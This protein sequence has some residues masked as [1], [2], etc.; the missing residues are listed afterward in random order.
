MLV[1]NNK[2]RKSVKKRPLFSF[3]IILSIIIAIIILIRSVTYRNAADESNKLAVLAK[4]NSTSQEDSLSKLTLPNVLTIDT[5]NMITMA[6]EHHAPIISDASVVNKE[7]K[8][9][10]INDYSKGNFRVHVAPSVENEP[11]QS[12]QSKNFKPPLKEED[13]FITSSVI[14][15]SKDRP[16]IS[17]VRGNL[18]PAS[19]V[20]NE[21]MNDW[22]KDRWQAA[23]NMNGEPIPGEHWLEIDLQRKCI[24]HRIL[25]DWEDAYSDA[26]TVNGALENSWNLIV[27]SINARRVSLSKYHLLQQADVPEINRNPVRK[28]RLT[29]HRPS[30]RWGVSVWRVQLWGVELK[31]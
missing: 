8:T 17:D 15:L 12:V 26:W 5:G 30:T 31:N 2:L 1:N 18:G 11:E 14:L 19:V 9:G 10:F 6:T 23:K 13:M 22:L 24:I 21:D 7:A 3:F 20:T 27:R 25:I 29:I 28:V 16:V 4:K